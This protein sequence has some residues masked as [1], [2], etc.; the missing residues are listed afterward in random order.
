MDLLVR[1]AKIPRGGETVPGESLMESLGG[2]GAN[3]AVAAARLGADVH[4]IGRVGDDAFGKRLKQ[5][6]ASEGIH[7]ADVLTTSG[8]SSGVAVVQVESSGENAIV[9]VPGA[10]G[11]LTPDDIE[12]ASSAIQAADVLMLQLEI[13]LA[14]AIAALQTAR[15]CGTLVVLDPAPTPTELPAELFCCDIICPNETEAAALLQV[16]LDSP[17]A[18]LAA[19]QQLVARGAREAIVK[20]GHRGGLHFSAET[21]PTPF[22][23]YPMPVVDTTAAGDAFAAGFSVARAEQRDLA[24]C[25]QWGA[26]AGALAVSR[27]GA[28]QAM[29]SRAELEALMASVKSPTARPLDD[30]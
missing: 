11:A 20:F 29:P 19:A 10:N 22:T 4:F 25:L 17:A 12:R 2:K 30:E 3:Q 15:R 24:E 26:A 18:E 5:G 14:T 28:Q 1:V 7:V 13:P 8:V 9:V 6:L 23:A 27:P 21:G 16:E